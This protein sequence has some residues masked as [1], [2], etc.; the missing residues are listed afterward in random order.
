MLFSLQEGRREEQPT[1]TTE[2]AVEEDEEED[3]RPLRIVDGSV[4][5]VT[6]FPVQQS[7][8][9]FL[10][11]EDEDEKYFISPLT[12]EI[13]QKVILSSFTGQRSQL[14]SQRRA[15]TSTPT[16]PPGQCPVPPVPPGQGEG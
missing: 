16:E 1:T 8:E 5:V 15:S 6:G 7:V 13:Y 12:A 14:P 4:Y 2:K 9:E 3:H 11:E 10:F